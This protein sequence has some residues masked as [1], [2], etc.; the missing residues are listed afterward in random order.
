MT[1]I[2][3]QVICIGTRSVLVE[4]EDF[5]RAYDVGYETYHRYHRDDNVI[6]SAIL[7]FQLRNGWNDTCSEMEHTGFIMGWL[8]G[9]YE[10][11]EGHLARSI[12][13]TMTD[14]YTHACRV[15]S[16]R[17]ALK[18]PP[19]VCLCGSTRFIEAFHVANLKE[20]LAGKI[21]LSI[22]CDFKSDHDLRLAGELTSHDK[23]R[24]DGLHLGKIALADE[25]L[26]LNV[27]GYMGESTRR[28]LAY[29]HSLGKAIRYLQP[30]TEGMC[31]DKGT[32]TILLQ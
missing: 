17:R 3:Q 4:D 9:F 5:A 13:V 16:S 1:H 8:A 14:A 31:D 11:E 29:A 24:L 12:D 20:T 7:L 15:H 27:G 23:E 25:V 22:G 32:A 26:F 2:Q 30:P 21:V 18:R 28:E 19:I 10:Q 6:D